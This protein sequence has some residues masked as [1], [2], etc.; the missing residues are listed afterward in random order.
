MQKFEVVS[1]LWTYVCFLVYSDCEIEV[2]NIKTIKPISSLERGLKL[3]LRKTRT[4]TSAGSDF[5]ENIYLTAD[6]ERN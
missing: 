3:T 5:V 6:E 1:S 2:M 4:E